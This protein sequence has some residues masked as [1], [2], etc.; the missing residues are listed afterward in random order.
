MPRA[1]ED[2]EL[3]GDDS[4]DSIELS[5]E[6]NFANDDED[7]PSP[8]PVEA[9]SEPETH[10]CGVPIWIVQ[11]AILGLLVV[12]NVVMYLLARYSQAGGKASKPYLKTTVVLMTE[13]LKLL[14]CF[15]IVSFEE[16]FGGML[17][18]VKAEVRCAVVQRVEM[19]APR[20]AHRLHQRQRV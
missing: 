16:G 12:Q 17:R 9:V 7:A 2:I 13:L 6:D 3:G 4:E 1:V 5:V 11:I 14:V 8:V 18:V 15:I 20:R 19:T 10:L